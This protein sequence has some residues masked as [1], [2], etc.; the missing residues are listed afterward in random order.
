MK[1]IEILVEVYSPISEVINVLDKFEYLGIKEV[2]DTYYYDPLR[3]NLKPNSNNQI[4]ECLRLRKT[5]NNNFITYKTDEF[6]KNGRWLYSNEYETKI[7]DLSIAM[8]ILEKIGLKELITIHNKKRTY[9]YKEYEI[10]LETVKDLGYFIEVE[11]C[12][13]KDIDIKKKKEEIQNFIDSLCL[14]VSKEL[15]IGKPE[16]MLNKL[17]IKVN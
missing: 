6:D 15:N 5:D 3:K 1:E 7:D 2:V 9:K 8:N 17:N 4:N 11:F 10:V 16:M 13:D 14:D 12:T